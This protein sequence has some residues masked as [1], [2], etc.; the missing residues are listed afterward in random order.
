[1][2]AER[3]FERSIPRGNS[4]VAVVCRGVKRVLT[5]GGRAYSKVT[6]LFLLS[7]LE[8]EIVPPYGTDF[9]NTIVLLAKIYSYSD[10]DDGRCCVGN[11]GEGFISDASE[12]VRSILW[13]VFEDGRWPER[14]NHYR[15]IR[16][17]P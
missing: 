17:L 7:C 2:K 16:L 15:L 1:M 14:C 11:D 6:V 8:P 12:S 13:S 3:K 5:S 4:V 9:W 10:L